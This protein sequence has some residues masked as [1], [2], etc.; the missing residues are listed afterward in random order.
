M[1]LR[2]YCSD[3]VVG[4][5]EAG[6]WPCPAAGVWAVPTSRAGKLLA[7]CCVML[8]LGAAEPQQVVDINRQYGGVGEALAFGESMIFVNTAIDTGTE[9]WISDGSHEGTRLLCD[10]HPGSAGS[11][12]RDLTVIGDLLWFSADDGQH[13]HE[14]WVSDGT[15]AGTRLV[16]DLEPGAA[17]SDPKHFVAAG[18]RVWF[19]AETTAQGRE[20]WL[21]SA[22]GS[23]ARLVADVRPGPDS[24]IV[25]PPSFLQLPLDGAKLA[26]LGDELLFAADDGVHGLELWRTDGTT[27]GMVEDLVGNGSLSV[28]S[29]MISLGD[30][31]FFFSTSGGGG[32]EP[33]IADGEPGGTRRLRDLRPGSTGCNPRALEQLGQRVYFVADDGSTGREIWI[34]DGTSDGTRLLKNV[35]DDAQEYGVEELTS[36]GDRLLCFSADAPG[37]S[38]NSEPWISDGTEA[39]TRLLSEIRPGGRGTSSAPVAFADLDGT[40]I[41]FLARQ[42]DEGEHLLMISDGTADGTR[43]LADLPTPAGAPLRAHT[44]RGIGTGSGHVFFLASHGELSDPDGVVDNVLYVSDGTAAGTRLLLTPSAGGGSSNPR[45]LMRF[46][47]SVVFSATPVFLDLTNSSGNFQLYTA[48]SGAGASRLKDINPRLDQRDDSVAPGVAIGSWLLFGASDGT[49]TSG[50]THGKELWRTDGTPA[51]TQLLMDIAEGNVDGVRASSNPYHFHALGTVAVFAVVRYGNG[52]TSNELWRSDGTSAERLATIDDHLSGF[53]RGITNGLVHDGRLFFT[54]EDRSHGRE[55][56][57][58]DGSPAGTMRLTDIAPGNAHAFAKNPAIGRSILVAHDGLVYFP[59]DDGEGS[60]LWCS[61]G[62]VVGSRRALQINATGS[63]RV[64]HVAA[65]GG[66]L[67]FTADDGIHGRELWVSDGSQANT[68]LVADIRSGADD[69]TPEVVGSI[70]DRVLL[71]ADDGLHGRELWI[72]DGT[73]AGTKRL[74]DIAP[75]PASPEILYPVMVEQ[76]LCFNANDGEHGRE[77]WISDGTSA[78]TR[79]VADLQP[80]RSGSDPFTAG[81]PSDLQV[82]IDGTLYFPASTPSGCELWSYRPGNGDGT[83]RLIRLRSDPADQILEFER[84]SDGL[85]RPSPAT[86]SVPSALDAVFR[87]HGAP[88]GIN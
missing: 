56:W 27:T 11:S 67:F 39:G 44:I 41:L 52:H 85:R 60:A 24:S 6:G 59:A 22:A 71:L 33:F 32:E 13:G 70:G 88:S 7:L 12:P 47:D 84:R 74:S 36:L 57:V 46:G 16:G 18:G 31:V 25:L 21:S 64:A 8:G 49:V 5:V 43:Y 40:S 58:S 55:L 28:C 45:A 15:V 30:R 3:R 63:D 76:Q 23:D 82:V 87:A 75:G 51:G 38:Y 72:S 73:S 50:D 37:T 77:L 79:M 48:A 20:L 17:G 61:D 2:H 26:A 42:E 9:L 86:F 68:R 78:G 65:A 35:T 80:G 34:S 81:G 53:V 62:S 4:T 83:D 10:I 1:L 66:R 14:P 69:S 19:L 54:A 29:R